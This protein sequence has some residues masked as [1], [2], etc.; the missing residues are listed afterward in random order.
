MENERGEIRLTRKELYDEIWKSS[1]AGVSRKYGLNYAKLIKACK[2]ACIPYPSSGY[3]T[4]Y[5]MGKDVSAEVIP[6]TGDENALVD[7]DGAP[8]EE[9][10]KKKETKLPIS[11][12]ENPQPDVPVIVTETKPEEPVWTSAMENAAQKKKI[13]IIP[14]TWHLDF[15]D[16]DEKQRVLETVCALEI[17]GNTRLHKALTQ[18]K[19][20][21]EEYSDRQRTER[22][23]RYPSMYYKPEEEPKFFNEMSQEGKKRACRILDALFKA[24]EKLGGSV[25]DDLSMRIRTDIVQIKIAE[26]KDK[27]KHELTKLEARDLLIYQDKVK[28]HS[29]ASKPKIPQYD[30]VYNGKLRIIFGEK[31][32]IRDS[33]EE[34]LEDR[35]GYILIKLYEKSEENRLERERREEIQRRREEEERRKEELRKRTEMEKKMTIELENKA[36]DYRVACDIRAYINALLIQGNEEITPEWIEW[37]KKKADW[38]DPIIAYEDEYLGKREHGKS[39]EEKDLNKSQMRRSSYWGI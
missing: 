24:V 31:N 18:Y 16:N 15:L 19:K 20:R 34:K 38:F 35:L 33:K 13:T 2:D 21:I 10:S 27:I 39:K 8:A 23:R 29:W 37:A 17:S 5:N 12:K 30:H 11:G 1:V 26:G 9:K 14:D 28:Q 6:L 25:N 4:K 7:L 32:Y 22:N 36:E 3:W